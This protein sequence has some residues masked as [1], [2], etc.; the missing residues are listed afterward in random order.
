[1]LRVV[2]W[3]IFVLIVGVSIVS[4]VLVR[5]YGWEWGVIGSNYMSPRLVRGDLVLL[6]PCDSLDIH[7]GDIICYNGDGEH[8]IHRVQHVKM[9]VGEM[10]FV[11]KGDNNELCDSHLVRYP[12]VRGK[13]VLSV[14]H[15][16]LVVEWLS[17]WRII[18]FDIGM[19]GIFLSVWIYNMR[20]KHKGKKLARSV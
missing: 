1:M 4:M 20:S 8:I 19:A 11:T 13:L 12:Q 14:R 9:G 2:F 7:N 10:E 17:G 6:R 3:S 18:L 5:V 16:G 15:I